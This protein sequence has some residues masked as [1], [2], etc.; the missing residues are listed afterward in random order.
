M[1]RKLLEEMKAEYRLEKNGEEI[2]QHLVAI[3]AYQELESFQTW[4]VWCADVD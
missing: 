3:R 4:L 2:R 1:N